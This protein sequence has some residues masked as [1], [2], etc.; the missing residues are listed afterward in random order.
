LKVTFPRCKNCREENSAYK[1]KKW[2]GNIKRKLCGYCG[3]HPLIPGHKSC[4]FCLSATHRRRYVKGLCGK[5][6]ER[7]ISKKSTALC[8]PCLKSNRVYSAA[9]R[10]QKELA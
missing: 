8:D 1:H 6:G 5:C 7:P 2:L 9:Y 4:K 3:E 10:T